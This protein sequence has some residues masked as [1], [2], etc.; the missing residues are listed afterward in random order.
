MNLFWRRHIWNALWN[1]HKWHTSKLSRMRWLFKWC[2]RKW[3]TLF[4]WL[5]Y[6]FHLVCQ[7]LI[8]SGSDDACT[9]FFTNAMYACMRVYDFPSSFPAY[10]FIFCWYFCA[11]RTFFQIHHIHV[12]PITFSISIFIILLNV[13]SHILLVSF[14][15][16]ARLVFPH[17]I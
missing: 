2:I 17:I 15:S 16:F 14:D 6:S 8:Y 5:A 10:L 9:P 13:E 12:C 4:H 1:K 11:F 7:R 3:V